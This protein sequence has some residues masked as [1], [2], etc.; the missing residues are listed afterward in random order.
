MDLL[1]SRRANIGLASAAF[2]QAPSLVV[3][4]G[5]YQRAAVTTGFAWLTALALHSLPVTEQPTSVAAVPQPNRHG[6]GDCSGSRSLDS[7][8][9][10]DS[11]VRVRSAADQPALACVGDRAHRRATCWTDRDR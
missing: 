10:L 8:T 7:E 4:G 6:V 2:S 11:S 9:A 5:L 1:R 3:N